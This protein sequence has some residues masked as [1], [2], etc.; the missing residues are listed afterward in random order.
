MVLGRH[1]H[2]KTVWPA[3]SNVNTYSS[4][5][6]KNNNDKKKSSEKKNI[7]TLVMLVAQESM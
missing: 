3:F 5:H 4:G 2:K 1:T 7:D 6:T